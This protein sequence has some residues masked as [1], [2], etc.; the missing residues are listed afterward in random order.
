M[1][2]K[3]VKSPVWINLSIRNGSPPIT[4]IHKALLGLS[5]NQYIV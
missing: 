3:H 5:E 4:E 2:K 1:E